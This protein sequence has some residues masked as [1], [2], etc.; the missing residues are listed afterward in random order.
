MSPIMNR[1]WQ[2]SC[3]FYHAQHS[4][5]G[6]L[7]LLCSGREVSGSEDAQAEEEKEQ[8]T[9]DNE[10]LP[11]MRMDPGMKA[12]LAYLYSLN[13]VS[14]WQTNRRSLLDCLLHDCKYCKHET[15]RQAYST[16]ANS[17]LY[18]AS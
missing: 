13:Q 5:T 16:G 18:A 12:K 9:G 8:S 7:S 17:C 15:A 3:M 11:Q 2:C 6:Q 10:Q 14:P 4:S 1:P